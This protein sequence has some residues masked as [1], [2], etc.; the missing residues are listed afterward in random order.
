[1]KP[2]SRRVNCF[3]YK[4][5]YLRTI[6][7]KIILLLVLLAAA[8]IG[9]Q[10]WHQQQAPA[11]RKARPV[12]N[13]V[14]Y[15][16]AI[17]A[18]RDEVEA[19]GTSKAYES[20]TITPKVSDVVTSIRFDDGQIVKQGQLLAKLQDAEQ[21]ARVE[22]ARIKVRENT[23]EFDRISSL[24]TSKTVAETERDRLQTLIESARA[25]VEQAQAALRDR[26]IT[27]PSMVAWVYARSR[28]AAWSRREW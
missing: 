12:P 19:L 27:A 8:A 22:L 26:Q 20:V 7:E 17:Q 11:E 1:M 23:R 18:V 28:S 25:E 3:T 16:A 9:Y 5:L 2:I 24:V 13:V 14:V 4:T 6:N 21:Q 10:Q 15:K